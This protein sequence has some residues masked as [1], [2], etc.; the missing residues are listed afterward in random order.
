MHRNQRNELY[1]LVL[2]RIR[3]E[4]TKKKKTKKSATAEDKGC[5]AALPRHQFPAALSREMTAWNETKWRET[6]ML[7]MDTIGTIHRFPVADNRKKSISA[8][9][10]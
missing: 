8:A 10:P 4:K 3:K 5:R 9:A 1:T 6:N 7:W 2:V